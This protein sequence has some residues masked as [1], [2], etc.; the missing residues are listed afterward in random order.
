MSAGRFTIMSEAVLVMITLSVDTYSLSDV[1]S[2]V[3]HFYE[4][5][6]KV[7]G[8]LFLPADLPEVIIS[9]NPY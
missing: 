2:V 7:S 5:L 1:M 3:P 8:H 4:L 9:G 6:I